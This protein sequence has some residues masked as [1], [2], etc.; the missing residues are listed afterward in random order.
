MA[1]TK[2]GGKKASVTNKANHGDDFYAKIGSLGGKAGN[3]GGFCDREL[4]RRAGA[5]GGSISRR[6]P[7]TRTHCKY[8][9]S[10]EDA[11][12]YKGNKNCRTCARL[13]SEKFREEYD[14]NTLSNKLRRIFK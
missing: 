12:I 8:G 10:L 9:H 7:S 2:A 6:G 4:A 1:G 3:T 5:K 14:R 11:Y 13:R